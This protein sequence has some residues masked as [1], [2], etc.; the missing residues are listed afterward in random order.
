MKIKQKIGIEGHIIAKDADTGEVLLD[1]YNTIHP[2]NMPRILARG[3]AN[4]P[5]YYVYRMALG[6][7]GI[8][9]DEAGNSVV[10]PANVDAWNTGLYNETYSVILD[11][12]DPSFDSTGGTGVVSA[13]LGNKSTVTVMAYIANADP[14]GEL[15]SSTLSS[16]S[17]AELDF[18]FNEMGLFCYGLPQSI[19]YGTSSVDVGNHVSTDEFPI[20][21]N[22]VLNLVATVNSVQYT[23]TITVPA[24]G[25]GAGGVITFGDFCEG[26]NSGAW[27]T[28]GTAL[29]VYL[30]TYIT[31]YTNGN[32]PT[33]S[34]PPIKGLP[35]A[36]GNLVFTSR[37]TGPTSNV[38]L[39]CT[40][41]NA[42]DFF[43][44]LTSNQCGDVNIN[45]SSGSNPGVQNDAT[46]LYN[47][48]PPPTSQEAMRMLTYINF[49]SVLK[50]YDRNMLFIYTITIS[51][52]PSQDSSASQT[53]SS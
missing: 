25:T 3:L 30:Y 16:P 29:N 13:E 20:T 19:T 33:L 43:N 31:D 52:T 50:A 48:C 40:S 4:E 38:T 35:L 34:N 46:Q 6:N 32:Y 28:G 7:A 45:Q 24:G 5:N 51:V 8:Y 26:F 9:V 53:T 1:Q 10:Q 41:G 18:N 12:T 23:S 15:A 2:D 21:P 14:G 39:S 11:S 17:G 22:S 27:I 47:T 49:N 44:A 42:S 36:Y 37:T